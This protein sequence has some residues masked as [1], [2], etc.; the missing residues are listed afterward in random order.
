MSAQ[1]QLRWRAGRGLVIL[2][3]VLYGPLPSLIDLFTPQHLMNPDWLGHARFHLLWQIFL[4][5]YI[6]LRA[7]WLAWQ[8]TPA[9]FQL[10]QRAA[11]LGAILLGAFYTAGALAGPTGAVFGEPDEVL[12][13]IPFPVVHLSTAALLL[14]AG[15][16][17]CRQAAAGV[18]QEPA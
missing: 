12:F 11:N 14:L 5:G 9:R 18:P 8:A 6:G 16:T 13:G 17:L 1:A 2:A 10:L 7:I 3:A 15:Y 4:T